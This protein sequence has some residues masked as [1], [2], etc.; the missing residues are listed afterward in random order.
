ML[1]DVLT[2]SLPYIFT[3]HIYAT[4]SLIGAV[5]FYLLRMIDGIEPFATIIGVLVIFVLRI[6][7]TKFHWKAPKIQ[8]EE[9]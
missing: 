1:R 9:K 7:A 3:K 8:I 5:V 2:N 6:L 4:A